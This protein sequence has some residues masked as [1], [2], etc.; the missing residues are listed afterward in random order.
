ML[1]LTHHRFE[2]CNYGVT[3]NF[4]DIVF[5]TNARN[6]NERIRSGAG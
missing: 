2:D 5:G 6:I 1:H 4:W 3:T